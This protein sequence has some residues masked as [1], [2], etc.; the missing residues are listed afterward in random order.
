M[1]DELIQRHDAAD[2][3][4]RDVG[5]RQQA[6]EAEPAGIRMRLLQVVHLHHQR[7][8]HLACRRMGRRALIYQSGE[9]FRFEASD[10]RIDRGA[11]HVQEAVN[12][13]FF[14]PPIIEG[15]DLHP[16]MIAIGL[17]VIVPQLQM[18]LTGD[19]T[20]LPERFHGLVINRHA[21][22]DK[23]DARQLA[24]A[25]AVVE[26]L[27]PIQLLLHRLWNPRRSCPD[28]DL[29][30]LREQ[31]HHPLLPKPAGERPHGGGM[32]VGFIRPLPRRPVGKED[33][34]PDHFVAPL[35]LVDG[36]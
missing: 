35:R 19:R 20:G 24:V 3:A 11:G 30:I 14:P 32:G 21:T 15:D 33:E 13:D 1:I 36:V 6:P 2:G 9:V 8:P 4:L 12:A 26:R 25:E 17:G 22:G 34:G 5:P 18:P 7:Q 16:G 23:Q 29:H 27:E 10:P 28:A 31:P